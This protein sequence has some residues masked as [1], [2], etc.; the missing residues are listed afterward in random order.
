MAADLAA[1]S[2]AKKSN[3]KVAKATPVIGDKKPATAV[4]KNT[5]QVE[6]FNLS[7]DVQQLFNTWAEKLKPS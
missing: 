7:N 3:D 4:P 2:N 5:A 6:R 1:D